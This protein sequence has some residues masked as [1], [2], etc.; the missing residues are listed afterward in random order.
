MTGEDGKKSAT[1]SMGTFL[2]ML[3]K[4]ITNLE[5]Y[6]EELKVCQDVTDDKITRLKE[7]RDDVKTRFI[8]TEDRWDTLVEQDEFKDDGEREKC[9]GDY[10]EAEKLHKAAMAAAEKAL[11]K[12]RPSSTGAPQPTSPSGPPKIVDTL[13]PKEPLSE[14]MNL[15]EAN[16]WFKSYRAHLAYNKGTLDQQDI[17]VQRAMLE[18]DLDPKMASAL[19]SHEKIK[20]DTKIDAAAPDVGCLETLREI[21]LEKNPV[22]LRRHWYFCCTQQ[23]NET[24]QN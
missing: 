2:G 9:E 1:R 5:G 24:V 17:Q 13:K 15:E 20:D 6:I 12:V 23:P 8:K 21:F 3:K 16:Q 18:V 4:K 10:N 11:E 19:R 14:E 22:W 7:L